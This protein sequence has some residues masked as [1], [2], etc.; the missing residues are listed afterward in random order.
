[1]PS[2][3]GKKSVV[4]ASSGERCSDW[5]PRSAEVQIDQI[6]AYDH[7]RKTVSANFRAP[8]VIERRAA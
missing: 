4:D 1:M 3:N 6:H 2:A 8:F 7:M 5:D